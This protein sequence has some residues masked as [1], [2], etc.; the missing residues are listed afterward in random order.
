MINT[1]QKMKFSVKDFFSQCDQI[2]RKQCI[3]SCLLKKSIMKNFIFLC[4]EGSY[5]YIVFFLNHCTMFHF[6]LHPILNR[7]NVSIKGI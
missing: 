6:E 4:S 3:W 1:A 7:V 5:L 2:R